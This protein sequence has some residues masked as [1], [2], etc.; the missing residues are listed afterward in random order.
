MLITGSANFSKNSTV[1]NDEN[2]LVIRGD[3]R[4]VDTYLGEFMRLFDH[5]QFR[6]TEVG[7]KTGEKTGKTFTL[8]LAPD[9]SW[10]TNYFRDGHPK[11]KERLLFRGY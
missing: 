4:V 3:K 10:T 11:A 5:F 2:M 8:N 9:D 6:G 7:P 1:N